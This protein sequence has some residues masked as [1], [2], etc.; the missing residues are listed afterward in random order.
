MSNMKISRRVGIAAVTGLLLVGMTQAS[1]AIGP[2][3]GA[4]H[5]K[6]RSPKQ[7]LHPAP[8]PSTGNMP[9]GKTSGLKTN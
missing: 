9:A 8:A 7:T 3:K 4:P 5:P 2:P 6:S 1:F